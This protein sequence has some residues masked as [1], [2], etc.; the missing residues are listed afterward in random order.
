ERSKRQPD[1]PSSRGIHISI[2]ISQPRVSPA[3]SNRPF[4]ARGAKRH[5]TQTRSFNCVVPDARAQ[6]TQQK[7]FPS[8]STPCPRI[9]QLQWGQT[10]ASAWI[11]H[12]KLSKV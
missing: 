6:W 3:A 9:R 7:I 11:A 1:E 5:T 8:A 4:C 12:S 2:C 10:G